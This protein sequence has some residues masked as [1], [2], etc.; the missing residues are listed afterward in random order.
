MSF[1]LPIGTL[2]SRWNM[3]L[4]R[5]CNQGG[6]KQNV[7]NDLFQS[8]HFFEEPMAWRSHLFSYSY[9]D[10]VWLGLSCK[11]NFYD[12]TASSLGLLISK[13][14]PRAGGQSKENW[15][16]HTIYGI[17]PRP[18]QISNESVNTQNVNLSTKKKSVEAPRERIWVGNI[19]NLV[20]IIQI[21][22]M[23]WN[24]ILCCYM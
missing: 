12:H 18:K 5:S 4:R 24:L 19:W 7:W 21:E 15:W 2:R 9:T 17:S 23:G 20:Y 11:T 6:I 22:W 10:Q 14:N 8:M 1:C 16:L 13:L 3:L